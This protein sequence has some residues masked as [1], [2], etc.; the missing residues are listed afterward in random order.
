M[1]APPSRSHQLPPWSSLAKV[2]LPCQRSSCGSS[3][4]PRNRPPSGSEP[5]TLLPPEPKLR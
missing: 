5:L 1:M 3:L 4:A 2:H